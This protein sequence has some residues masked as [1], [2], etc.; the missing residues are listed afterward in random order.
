MID[1]LHI[2]DDSPSPCSY[3]DDEVARL[4]MALPMLPITPARFDELMEFGYRRSGAFFYVTQCPNCSACEPIRLDVNCFDLSRTHRRALK[5]AEDLRF[6]W[7]IAECDEARVDLFNKH[8]KGR[9]LAKDPTDIDESGYRDFLLSAPNMTLELS[10]WLEKQLLS[11]SITDVGQ[12]SFS[13]VYCCFNPE[14]ERYGLGTLSVLK[15]IEF[16]KQHHMKWLY[17]GLYVRENAHLSYKSNYRPHQRRINGGQE[18]A[19]DVE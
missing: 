19:K 7:S 13:A 1:F 12:K 16:A 8:R 10:I 14:F 4:P 2:I 3:L 17:L 11:V 9:G 6:K 15:Q 5:R 18:F